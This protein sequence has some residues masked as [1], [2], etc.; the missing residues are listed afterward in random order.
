MQEIVDTEFTLYTSKGKIDIMKLVFSDG[1][2]R[3]R[4]PEYTGLDR[5][6]LIVSEKIDINTVPMKLALLQSLLE[7][8]GANTCRL[9]FRYLP[10]A[11][12]DRLFGKGESFGLDAFAK[13]I[14]PFYEVFAY[15]IHNFE[16]AE[17]LI[18]PITDIGMNAFFGSACLELDAFNP[19]SILI[20]P[21][22]GAKEKVKSVAEYFELE[23]VYAEK[24]RDTKT[25]QITD[26]TLSET[27]K[28]KGRDCVIVDDICDGGGTFIPLAKKLKE[29][30]AKTVTLYV[31]HGIFSKGLDTLKE[32]IDYIAPFQIIGNYVTMQDVENFNERN[33]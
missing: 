22:K 30:G 1:A 27:D 2:I 24:I 5:V 15:D 32:H 21:D 31:T 3:Y 26:T 17:N 4:L 20:S 11:R 9:T 13:L 29:A 16:N 12:A 28:V 7:N 10:Y 25:G 19:E 6:S 23:A 14:D 33:K 8:L 18:G